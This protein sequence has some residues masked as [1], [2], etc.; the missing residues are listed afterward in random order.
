[1]ARIEQSDSHVVVS[2]AV[3]PCRLDRVN[4][5]CPNLD[6]CTLTMTEPV[7]GRLD[8]CVLLK[9]ALSIEQAVDWL[10]G[11]IPAVAITRELPSAP[12][13]TRHLTDVSEPHSVPSH[14]L[15]PSSTL[16]VSIF[17]PRPDPY[18]VTD[19]DPVPATLDTSRILTIPR[20]LEKTAVLVPSPWA[21][22]I[23]TRCE[24]AAP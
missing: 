16:S 23:S 22:V 24:L 9:G 13:P 5:T 15:C 17:K 12:C 14:P 18:T 3:G 19:V 21:A 1:M 6:P 11:R 2:Q 7:L 8:L 10:R 4:A 20:S